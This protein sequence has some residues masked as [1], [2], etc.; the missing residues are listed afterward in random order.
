MPEQGLEPSRD[1]RHVVFRAH[2]WH[3]V[4]IGPDAPALVTAYIEIVPTDTVKYEIDKETG[5]LKVDRPQKYSSLCPSLYGFIPRT[6][7]AERVA[8]LCVQRT[9]RQGIVGDGDPMDIC[10]LSER[11][12]THADILLRAI[13]IGGFRMIDRGQADDKVVA[14]LRG[15]FAYGGWQD[16]D[17]VPRPLLDRLRHYFLTYKDVPGGPSPQVE[18]TGVYGREEALDLIRRSQ[19]DYGAHFGPLGAAAQ[20]V[21]RR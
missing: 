19:E 7:C 21:A 4:D 2:P 8:E 1:G 5:I 15:D 20:G 11:T 17:E 6:L 14:V 13:P 10:V 12:I 16:I 9:G 18:I 3:G